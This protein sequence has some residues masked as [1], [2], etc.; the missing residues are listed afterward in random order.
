MAKTTKKSGTKKTN[1][2]R[3]AAA[4]GYVKE[5]KKVEVKTK[6][7]KEVKE[8]VKT[9]V[10]EEEPKKEIKKEKK[11]KKSNI[12]TKKNICIGVAVI[13]IVAIIVVLICFVF[14]KSNEAELNKNFEIIGRKFYE[15]NYYNGTGKDDKARAKFLEKFKDSGLRINLDNLS[16]YEFTDENGK[17]YEFVNKKTKNECDKEASVVVIYPQEPYG[18]TD[19][20]IDAKLSCGFEK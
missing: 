9:L 16:R 8:A 14:N 2:S 3:S 5:T 19:Y 4:K 20:I 1:N 6:A 18:K 11:A 17:K 12:F 13:A 7:E 10:G 15:E